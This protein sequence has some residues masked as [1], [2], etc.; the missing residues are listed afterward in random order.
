MEDEVFEK[1]YLQIENVFSVFG[2][3][4]YDISEWK[5][6]QKIKQILEEIWQDG[7]DKGLEKGTDMFLVELD[8]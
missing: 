8:R 3:Y 5:R 4:D 6:K 7:Y 2:D 1:Y